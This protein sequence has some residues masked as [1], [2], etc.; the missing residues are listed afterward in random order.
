MTLQDCS[1]TRVSGL[2]CAVAEVKG[3][4]LRCAERLSK[5]SSRFALDQVT[6]LSFCRCLLTR[7]VSRG[8]A[9]L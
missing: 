7:H 2:G 3:V 9:G 6:T 4:A 1:S 8:M 5:V